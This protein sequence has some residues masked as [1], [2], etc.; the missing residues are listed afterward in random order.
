MPSQKKKNV[1]DIFA[2]TEDVNEQQPAVVRK[3]QAARANRP[4]AVPQ[5]GSTTPLPVRR[6]PARALWMILIVAAVVIIVG[7]VIVFLSGV[8][9]NSNT[10]TTANTSQANAS[11]NT[12]ATTNRS[13]VPNANES[14]APVVDTTTDDT[15][16]DGLTDTEEKKLKTNSLLAD[17]DGD[18]LSDRDEV[19]VYETNPLMSDTDSDG[20]TDGAEVASGYNPKGS[21]KL[22][23]L[24]EEIKKLE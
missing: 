13:L 12:A 4:A 5:A 18:D 20:N 19:K 23:D 9:T 22:Y 8:F 1:E 15:D 17:T 14:T 10:E 3:R 24:M 21:G 6:K 11:S 7:A 16:G 2:D